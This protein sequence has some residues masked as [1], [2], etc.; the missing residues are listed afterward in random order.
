MITQQRFIE[1]FVKQHREDFLVELKEKKLKKSEKLVTSDVFRTWF[2]EDWVADRWIRAVDHEVECMTEE[3]Q[4][5]FLVDYG[6]NNAL[7]L[8][9]T[10]GI[11]EL[12]TEKLT[13][14][15]IDSWYA[16]HDVAPKFF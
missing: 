2:N 3:D 7:E 12:N 4:T 11:E 1:R 6:L 8:A 5:D 13:W 9:N 15:V 16:Y 10:I 14:H